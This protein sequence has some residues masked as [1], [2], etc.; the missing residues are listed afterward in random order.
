MMPREPVLT[1]HELDEALE[2]HDRLV[3]AKI[4][5][6]PLPD[7]LVDVPRTLLAGVIE[8][9]ELVLADRQDAA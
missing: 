7:D 8:D 6:D 9:L 1:A 2:L 3:A 4:E 5:L